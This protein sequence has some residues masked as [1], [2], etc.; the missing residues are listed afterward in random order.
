MNLELLKQYY[1]YISVALGIFVIGGLV[2]FWLRNSANK[3][4]YTASQNTDEQY[5]EQSHQEQSYEHQPNNEED[6]TS[7]NMTH[8]EAPL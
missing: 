4:N 8:E 7:G 3:N 1:L 6:D 5:Q 2:L